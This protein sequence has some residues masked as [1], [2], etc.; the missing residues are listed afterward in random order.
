MHHI[1]P[2]YDE[3]YA[4]L[5]RHPLYGAIEDTGQLKIFMQHNVYAVW[6]FM[7]LIKALQSYIASATTPWVPEHAPLHVRFINQ[8]V[9]EEESDRTMSD[10]H[11]SEYC[12][13]YE[14]YYNAMQEIGADTVPME[15]FIDTVKTRGL[16]VALNNSDTPYP[17]R[18][19]VEF[20]FEVIR[21]G[22]AHVVAAVLAYGR[23]LLIP[24]LFK[25]LLNIPNV[26]RDLTPTL[27]A[28]L[29]RH[30][31][32]DEQDHGPI[33]ASL[34]RSL[35]GNN[36]VKQE[37]VRKFAEQALEARLSFWD[38]IYHALH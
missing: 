29:V 23:E 20:T 1:S 27:H 14:S 35:C 9:L 7:S 19:F 5:S 17:A 37:D 25:G 24:K 11:E 32:L 22:Q 30:I 21:S 12:S 34:V 33:T 2:Y 10:S 36:L 16:D 6:D 13:H 8:L 38:G 31:E 26:N 15:N 28:Y 4:Q 3:K 18:E